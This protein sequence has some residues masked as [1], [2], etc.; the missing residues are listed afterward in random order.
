M[1]TAQQLSV[2]HY[3]RDRNRLKM[4]MPP[5]AIKSIKINLQKHIFQ[6]NVKSSIFL[7]EFTQFLHLIDDTDE[8]FLLLEN[9]LVKFKYMNMNTDNLRKVNIGSIVMKIMHHF[10]RDEYAQKVT[11]ESLIIESL[12]CSLMS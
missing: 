7:N 3:V 5:S 4:N 12:N 2:D 9:A 1:Y 11:L 10:G 6:T 8:D